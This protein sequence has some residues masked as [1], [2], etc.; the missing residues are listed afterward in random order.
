MLSVI[1]RAYLKPFA[2]SK[3]PCRPDLFSFSLLELNPSFE[4]KARGDLSNCSPIKSAENATGQH[5]SLHVRQPSKI[6]RY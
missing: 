1:W 5:L 6:G 2:F 3:R 4:N